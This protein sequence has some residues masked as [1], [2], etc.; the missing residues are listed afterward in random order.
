MII[1][2]IKRKVEDYRLVMEK[3]F[4]ETE[5]FVLRIKVHHS[6][7]AILRIS[8]FT[9]QISNFITQRFNNPLYQKLWK[10]AE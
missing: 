6:F 8:H 7:L 3:S 2:L 10:T 9:I 1:D 4:K 5:V